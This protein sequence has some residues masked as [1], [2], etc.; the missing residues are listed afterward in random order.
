LIEKPETP[1]SDLAMVG[2]YYFKNSKL[3]FDSISFL[4]KNK[5]LTKGA[6]QLTDALQIMINKGVRLLIRMLILGL[7]VVLRIIY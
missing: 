1:V 3:L 5:I 2:M 6:Y 7:I 4:I